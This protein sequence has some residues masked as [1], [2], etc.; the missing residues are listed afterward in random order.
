MRV[1][2]VNPVGHSTW[3][4]KDREIYQSFASPET[5]IDVVSLPEGPPSVETPEAHAEVIPLVVK[6]VL[7]FKNDYDGFIVNCFLDPGVDLLKGL[8]DKPVV[9]PCESS[10]ALASIITDKIGIVTA[11]TEGLWMIEDRVKTIGFIDRVVAI[12]G[13]EVG[14]LDI[15]KDLDHTLRELVKASRRA[16]EKGAQVIVL[17]C[18]GFAGLAEK[19]SKEIGRP[20]VDPAGAAIKTL[21]ALIKLRAWRR[22]M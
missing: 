12:E 7:E 16:I 9:G 10:L 11:G 18:T 21:E 4:E 13:T 19:L 2:V 3:D 8:L 20:V 5:V 14:V 6:R 17:G 22:R 1:L 15:D